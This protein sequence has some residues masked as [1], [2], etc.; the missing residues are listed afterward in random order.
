MTIPSLC[1]YCKHWTN[2]RWRGQIM[3]PLAMQLCFSKSTAA[4]GKGITVMPMQNVADG[5]FLFCCSEG[6]VLR[7]FHRL[8]DGLAAELNWWTTFSVLPRN[9]R[10]SPASHRVSPHTIT[11][12][13]V[14][15]WRWKNRRVDIFPLTFKHRS[16]SIW[17]RRFTTLQRTLFIYLIKKYI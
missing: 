10:L 14:W 12:Q 8:R 3:E 7:R 11:H 6:V 13:S 9:W 5:Y 17:D 15:D 4:F 2:I 16:F 1:I